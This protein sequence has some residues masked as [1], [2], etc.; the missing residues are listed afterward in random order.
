MQSTQDEILESST[1]MGTSTI[2]SAYPTGF[3][4]NECSYDNLSDNLTSINLG[5]AH[6]T[7]SLDIPKH[8][9]TFRTDKEELIIDARL[10]FAINF[11]TESFQPNVTSLSE[12]P[13]R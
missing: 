6:G 3:L 2:L 4:E 12:S 9:L 10:L 11:T 13:S 7:L 5:G 1:E 8:I